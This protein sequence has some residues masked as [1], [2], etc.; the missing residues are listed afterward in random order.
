MRKLLSTTIA[1]G[2]LA[3]MTIAAPSF[4][5][6]ASALPS[7]NNGTNVDV[8][9]SGNTMN[10]QIQGGNNA[11]GTANWNSFNVGSDATVNFE[12]TS[13]N[14]T[15]LNM[16]SA[17]G[18]MSQ[19]YGN[20]TNS[21]CASCNYAATGKVILINP[22]GVLFGNGANV[23]LNSFTVSTLEGTYDA[24]SH[25]LSLAK[26]SNQSDNG[27][28]VEGGANIYG[29][30]NVTFASNNIVQYA[31]S[32]ISTNTEIN[33]VTGNGTTA[34]GNVKLITADGVNFYYYKNGS[35]RSILSTT[36]SADKMTIA[37]NGEITSGSIDV[38]NL[39][40]DEESA[41]N[42]KN[43][44]LKAVKAEKG[45]DGN[46]S[47]LAINQINAEDS[48]MEANK[49]TIKSNK[50]DVKTSKLDVNNCQ[51]NIYAG[52]D[53]EAD[54]INVESRENGLVAEAG[55]NVTIT[56][57][58]TLSISRLVAENGNMSITANKVIAGLP[59]TDETK[60]DGDSSERS[61]I[62]VANG[63][64]TS[65]TANDSYEVTAS[66]DLTA[67]G[68]Y[69]QKHHIQYG[70]GAEKILLVTKTPVP[71]EPAVE[72]T[73]EPEPIPEI[74]EADERFVIDDGQAKMLNKLPRQP[75]TYNNN[76]NIRDTRTSF[77]DVFAAA[78]Q[79][80]IEEE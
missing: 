42:I 60:L 50:S 37:L 28:V 54:L 2:L 73:P 23:N 11:V 1:A 19:I 25:Q 68:Q 32:K 30:K 36:E 56:T 76:T 29:D 26:T 27:I 17:S 51:T 47:L 59:Y 35:M 44:T 62:Y 12:F 71:Q 38:R 61:Y 34:Y 77:V 21:S 14:Q 57:D 24:D 18:G 15:S 48:S 8:T 9:T 43:A 22:N 5:L 4:A 33:D 67:D 65:N 31:G 40:T 64:F 66:G 39:S 7:F 53:I 10:V 52:N 69:Y 16:V 70:D 49:I 46:I 13:T 75:E 55:K 3:S 80:E 45:N 63:T 6:D 74:V 58:G 20:I 41:I 72:P 79:I 78:S